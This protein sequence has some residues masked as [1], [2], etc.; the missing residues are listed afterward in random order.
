MKTEK[1]S[2]KNPFFLQ[3]ALISIQLVL[4]YICFQWPWKDF[5]GKKVSLWCHVNFFGVSCL[6]LFLS[7]QTKNTS[8][9]NWLSYHCCCCFVFFVFFLFFFSSW[10]C[11]DGWYDGSFIRIRFLFFF[12]F[13]FFC[14]LFFL[15]WKEIIG[16]SQ[17]SF[18]ISK[19]KP[20]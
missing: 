11:K 14:R 19:C 6:F 15:L 9:D 10:N 13:F 8:I 20:F 2:L 5:R 17:I 3:Y 16:Y 18:S 4:V 7:K 1:Q 12:F